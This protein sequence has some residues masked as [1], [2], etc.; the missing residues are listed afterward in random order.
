MIY[1]SGNSEVSDIQLESPVKDLQSVTPE[2]AP[3]VTSD[4]G[5]WDKTTPH[6]LFPRNH[7]LDT[8]GKGVRVLLGGKWVELGM[9]K[10]LCDI[11]VSDADY[12][13][14]YWYTVQ[15]QYNDHIDSV[16]K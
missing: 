9:G 12:I 8:V 14:K 4:E 16:Y 11:L 6:E 10:H 2:G 5:L 7:I 1:R 15:P 13:I 3:G